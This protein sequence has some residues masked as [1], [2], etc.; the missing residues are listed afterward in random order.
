MN[1]LLLGGLSFLGRHLVEQGLQRG[2]EITVFTRGRRNPEL[3]GEV[4]KLRGD[5]DGDLTA[6]AG[7][8][9]DVAIDTSGYVPR[10]VRDST[11]LLTGAVEHYTFVS[12]LSVYADTRTPW[13]DETAP[14]ATLD[15]PATEE[16]TGETYGP[17]KAQAERAAEDEMPGRTLIVRPGLIV[18]KYDPTDRFTYWPHRVARGG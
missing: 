6:L 10:I 14:V 16:I 15:D 12:S 18:G 11:R 8:R 7:R 3:Y 5:R 4:E 1:V 13:Q 9:W 2:N 17:L